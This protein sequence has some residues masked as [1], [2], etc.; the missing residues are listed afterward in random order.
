MKADLY[1]DLLIA[2]DYINYYKKHTVAGTKL[3]VAVTYQ[4]GLYSQ[5]LKIGREL[6]DAGVNREVLRP[7]PMN[8][9]EKKQ[10]LEKIKNCLPQF[11]E[12]ISSSL[13]CMT[14]KNC[15]SSF[16]GCIHT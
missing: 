8:F 6:Y 9:E 14:S 1:K 2:I 15:P 11:K 7:V 16:W 5:G 4:L 13:S 3:Y 12:S 10:A